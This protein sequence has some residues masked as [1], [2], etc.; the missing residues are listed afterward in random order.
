MFA[1]TQ[2]WRTSP[3][4]EYLVEDCLVAIGNAHIKAASTTTTPVC[5]TPLVEAS[6]THSVFNALITNFEII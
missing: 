2:K 5:M 4:T 6:A 1:V 3:I